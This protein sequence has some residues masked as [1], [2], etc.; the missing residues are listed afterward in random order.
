M[1]PAI[2]S[3]IINLIFFSPMMFARAQYTPDWSSLDKRPLPMW[4]DESKIGI[5]IHWGVFSVPSVD[6]EWYTW[7]FFCRHKS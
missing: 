5:F 3:I 4:Y 6:S 2:T 7:F 1:C